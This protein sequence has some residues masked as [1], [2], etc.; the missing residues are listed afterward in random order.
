VHISVNS[1]SI[2]KITSDF[3][4]RENRFFSSKSEFFLQLVAGGKIASRQA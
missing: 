3:L 4:L 2:I 1:C